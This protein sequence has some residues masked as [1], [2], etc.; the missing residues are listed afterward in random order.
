MKEVILPKGVDI[1]AETI[2]FSFIHELFFASTVGLGSSWYDQRNFAEGEIIRD[3]RYEQYLPEG[4]S[5]NEWVNLLGV[6]VESLEHAHL[7]HMLARS[8]LHHCVQPPLSWKGKIA[9]SAHFSRQEQEII[10]L[11][12]IVHD[13]GE[14]LVGDKPYPSKTSA[15]ELEEADA[16]R[17]IIRDRFSERQSPIFWKKLNQA[18]EIANNCD[19]KL[20]RAFNAIE[21][22]GYLRT[23]IVAWRRSR[24][25]EIEKRV[26]LSAY[27]QWLATE[28]L[29]N[30]LPKLLEYAGIYPPVSGYL[31]DMR[32]LISDIFEKAPDSIF[33]KYPEEERDFKK[34][35]FEEAKEWWLEF[36]EESAKRTS[37]L[38]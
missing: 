17:R 26:E 25:T 11:A 3:V 28:V 14:M 13:W 34:A 1:E 2:S 32:P 19:S 22:L 37:G 8:F 23:G 6:D 24:Q 20:G 31:T 33:E 27:L 18:F 29:T 12:T 35:R 5:F 38:G 15:D 9:K 30:H 7:T 36:L 10:L 4:V 21:K 16:Q